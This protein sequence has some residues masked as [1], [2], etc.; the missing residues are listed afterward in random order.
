MLE[1]KKT[2]SHNENKTEG[3]IFAHLGRRRVSTAQSGR[4]EATSNTTNSSQIQ[5]N[6][7][8]KERLFGSKVKTPKLH[9]LVNEGDISKITAKLLKK[10]T[11]VNKV[12]ESNRTALHHAAM[13]G[14]SD[15]ISLLCELGNERQSEG[16]KGGIVLNIQDFEGRTPLM[17]VNATL[18]KLS[19]LTHSTGNHK[20]SLYGRYASLGQG[21]KVRIE[22]LCPAKLITPRC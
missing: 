6:K 10:N 3:S 19:G 14:A 9:A 16:T 21:G 1:R 12:D 13:K 22:G 18:F 4:S 15:V 8:L 5:R 2:Q 20:R 17:L 11:N 7:S